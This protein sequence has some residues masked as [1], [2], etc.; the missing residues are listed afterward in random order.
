MTVTLYGSLADPA[1]QAQLEK[2]KQQPERWAVYLVQGNANERSP[3]QNRLFRSILRKLA[4][5]QG[6]SVQYW[7]DFLVERFLGFDDVITEDGYIRK[8]LASTSDMSVAEFGEF[9]NACLAFLADN[10]VH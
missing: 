2:A 3:A 9:L 10:Q 7:H 6:R 1:V 8:V 5:Q 4:Q